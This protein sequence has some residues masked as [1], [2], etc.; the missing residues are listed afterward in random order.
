MSKQGMNEDIIEKIESDIYEDE[1]DYEK[2][3]SMLL[4]V[5]KR[6]DDPGEFFRS[7]LEDG[8]L[9]TVLPELSQLKGIPA[10][11]AKYHREDCFEHSVMV[12]EEMYEIRGN[13][14]T[15]LL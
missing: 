2:V 11:P 8:I 4:D 14:P 12:L 5:M 3:G 6:S 1:I 9:E 7:A 15:A 13:E 10:G